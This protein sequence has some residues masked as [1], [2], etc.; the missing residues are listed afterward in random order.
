MAVS[1]DTAFLLDWGGLNF[2]NIADPGNPLFIGSVDLPGY[3]SFGIKAFGDTAFVGVGNKEELRMWKRGK[4]VKN[5]HISS[6]HEHEIEI[7]WQSHGSVSESLEKIRDGSLSVNLKSLDT[8]RIMIPGCFS[9]K[10]KRG[11]STLSAWP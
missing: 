7:D 1:G 9:Q 11:S 4:N 8:G 2:I 3:E 5:H 6:E 10:R